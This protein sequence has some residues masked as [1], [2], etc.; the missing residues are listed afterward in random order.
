MTVSRRNH[1]TLLL[2]P[3]AAVFGTFL[4][5]RVGFTPT[6]DRP[7]EQATN[8]HYVHAESLPIE[9]VSGLLM[10]EH[11]ALEAAQ[12]DGVTVA[13]LKAL[14]L[15]CV[16]STSEY[17]MDVDEAVYCQ[18][19]AEALMHRHFDGSFEKLLSWWRSQPSLP[20]A[21]STASGT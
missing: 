20:Q 4:I 10:D 8:A 21:L 12:L 18:A 13:R 16:R 11:R 1:A 5:L 19:V 17:R 6:V 14:Y 9:V 7:V 3:I 15:D 2:A